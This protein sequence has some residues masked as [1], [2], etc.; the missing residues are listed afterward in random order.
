MLNEAES[1]V[2]KQS[3]KDKKV[4]S[5]DLSLVKDVSDRLRALAQRLQERAAITLVTD[6]DG[7][8]LRAN[9]TFVC[10]ILSAKGMIGGEINHEN[11]TA[12]K[13]AWESMLPHTP[14]GTSFLNN[15]VAGAIPEVFSLRKTAI[16]DEVTKEIIAYLN[17]L[18]GKD[19]PSINQDTLEEVDS[20]LSNLQ[21]HSSIYI[22]DSSENP[23]KHI[24]G[25]QT[26]I[27]ELE[28]IIRK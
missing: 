25:L 5:E 22:Y 17:V 15:P 16:E 28:Q 7:R 11:L 9:G 20:I 24:E 6:V 23:E 21:V 8:I 27:E 12:N 14:L 2:L 10:I 19:S 4:S 1:L 18:H 13:R 26:C 3:D